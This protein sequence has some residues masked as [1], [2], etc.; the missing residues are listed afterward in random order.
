[1]RRESG[2]GTLESHCYRLNVFSRFLDAMSR[3]VDG[4]FTQN[5]K[6]KG[7]DE[8]DYPLTIGAAY[9]AH[10]GDAKKF[11]TAMPPPKSQVWMA[12][13][14]LRLLGGLTLLYCRNPAATTSV[15]RATS[16]TGA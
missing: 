13:L 2:K 5:I 7:A 14:F 8:D 15:P 11:F 3:S 10:E 12:I 1:M 4:N 16:A 9:V 6:D